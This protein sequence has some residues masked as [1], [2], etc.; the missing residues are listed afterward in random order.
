MH[1]L[2]LERY[3]DDAIGSELVKRNDWAIRI[4]KKGREYLVEHELIE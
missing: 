3:L 1:R 4:T 2:T